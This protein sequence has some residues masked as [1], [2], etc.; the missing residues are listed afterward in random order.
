MSAFRP[1]LTRP[2]LDYPRF[3]EIPT[4]PSGTSLRRVLRERA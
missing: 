3:D 1:E 2:R 4:N